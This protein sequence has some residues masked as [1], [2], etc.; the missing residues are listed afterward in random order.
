MS[1][2]VL[3]GAGSGGI[4]TAT[5]ALWQTWPAPALFVEADPIGAGLPVGLLSERLGPADGLLG[6]AL[7]TGRGTSGSAE[8]ARHTLAVDGERARLLVTGVTEPAQYAAIAAGVDRL[9]SA[10]AGLAE[11]DPPIDVLIDAGRL[12]TACPGLLARADLLLMVVRGTL[13][14]AAAAARWLPRLRQ[15]C[16]DD[17]DPARPAIRLLVVGETPYT[18]GE[19]ARAVG[20]E[21][22]GALPWDPRAA[23]ALMGSPGIDPGWSR[24]PLG[25]AAGA[26]A[27]R[28]AAPPPSQPVG[29]A[30]PGSDQASPE[31]AGAVR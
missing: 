26:L 1:I 13:A 21:V 31:R 9:M 27:A 6:W 24:G 25:R 5:A 16:P 7:A 30:P 18:A 11:D 12:I 10:W 4:S 28:L 17:D 20:V 15:V 8:L 22:A 2:T 14:G 29:A 3:T 19:V 23:A